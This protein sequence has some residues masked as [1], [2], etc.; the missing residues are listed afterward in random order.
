[1]S[2]SDLDSMIIRLQEQIRMYK[3]SPTVNITYIDMARLLEDM[4]ELIS[5]LRHDYIGFKGGK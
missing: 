1:M 3:D 4:L 2:L 5:I